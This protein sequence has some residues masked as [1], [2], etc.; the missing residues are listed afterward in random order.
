MK[1]VVLAEP[2]IE[3]FSA[4]KGK[5]PSKYL[6]HKP[7]SKRLALLVFMWFFWY[8][9]NYGFLGDAATLLSGQGVTISS[10][11]LFLAVG[12]VGYPIGAAI[13]IVV[14]DRIERKLLIFADT[15]VWLAGMALF[16]YIGNETS[17]VLGSFLASL[18][19]GMY[20]QVAYTFT[21]ESYP[22]RARSSGFA[23][24]DGLGH[25]GGAFG[26]LAV[27]IFVALY[28]FQTGLR[29]QVSA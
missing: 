23:L 10:S 2:Q 21:A 29:L 9:G 14:A 6:F 17:V 15:I 12:A 25:I 20:L 3:Q 27:P 7:Y 19:L 5:F 11:I 24:S 28:G 18:A 1:G 13:M 8:I 26:A 16:G 22:T 4:E